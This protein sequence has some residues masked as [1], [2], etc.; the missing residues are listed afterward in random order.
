MSETTIEMTKS[1]QERVYERIRD[2][3]GELMTDADLKVL[4]DAACQKAFFE[5]RLVASSYGSPT[6]KPS[7]I[8]E[9][10]EKLLRP[11]VGD[12]VKQ[13]CLNHPEDIKKIIDEAIAKGM[14][15]MVE[16]YFTSMVANAFPGMYENLHQ[17]LT[18]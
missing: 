11:Q 14:F 1:F 13:W 18:Q 17:R 5:E 12:A 3:I 2:S 9:E 8:V 4:V 16:Q 7:L 15:G 10:V 6:R